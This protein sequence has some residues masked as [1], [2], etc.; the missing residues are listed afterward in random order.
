MAG[1]RIVFNHFPKLAG[2]M[3]VSL[4]DV[5]FET[6]EAIA[7]KSQATVDA[8]SRRTGKL[9]ESVRTAYSDD[10][11]TAIA[12]YDDFKAVWLEYGTGEP[13]P[14]RAEPYLT[15][16]AEG[17]RGRFESAVRSIEP[18]LRANIA[19]SVAIRANLNISYSAKEMAPMGAIRRPR[20]SIG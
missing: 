16:A 5:V 20:K 15:P 19:G 12:G 1:A 14:T 9:M 7:D 3:R 18:R 6:A 11:L 8:N 2:A 10:G 13:A 17:E 4:A